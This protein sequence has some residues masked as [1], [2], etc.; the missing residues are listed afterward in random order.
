MVVLEYIHDKGQSLRLMNASC[1]IFNLFVFINVLPS[2]TIIFMYFSD[3]R[4][5][6]S[7][8]LAMGTW[9]Q[10]LIWSSLP[11]F[12]PKPYDYEPFKVSRMRNYYNMNC[13]PPLNRGGVIFSLQFV[14]V[15][16]CVRVS[17]R[18]SVC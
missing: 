1:L 2:I 11:L 18:L 14:C 13:I 16:V 7:L 3:E 12:L 9:L 6:S 8:V 15:C 5:S 17:V 10:A 4:T